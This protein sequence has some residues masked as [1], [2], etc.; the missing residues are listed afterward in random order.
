[1]PSK[2]NS[3]KGRRRRSLPGS[4]ALADVLYRSAKQDPTRRF[5]ALYDKVARRDILAEAWRQ[6][7]ANR[8]APG[9][10]GVTIEDV[11]SQ[12]PAAFLQQIQTE[13]TNRTYRP[14]RLRAVQ[15]EKP[16]KPGKY[17]TLGIPT[18]RDRTIMTAAA[19]VLQPIFEPQF[20]PAS[21][22]FRPGK[23]PQDALEA[24]RTQANRGADWVL[25]ADVQDAFGNLDHAA[26]MEEVS[27]RVCDRQM[28]KLIRAWLRAGVL[29]DQGV[30]DLPSG[31]PQGSPISPLL[32]NVALHRFDEQWQLSSSRIGTLVRFAD[33]WLILCRTRQGAEEAQRRATAILGTL[34]LQLNPDKTKVL[35]LTKGSQGLEFLGFHLH[36]VESWKYPGRY[37]LQRWPSQRSMASIRGRIRELTNRK[38]VGRA[39]DMVIAD[40]NP[41]LRGWGNYFRWGNSAAKLNAID[42]YVHERLAIFMSRKHKRQ[43]RNWV[44]R[45]NYTWFSTLGVYRL[46]GNTR[47][48]SAHAMR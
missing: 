42:S 4:R 12:G 6:V 43:G 48:G 33:D 47:Y 29:K 1:M 5:H 41:I 28:L 3:T 31:T 37:Y 10:D 46:T 11:E 26:L 15:I 34:G 38:Q 13:L 25:T 19:M 14:A 40:L 27:K 20:L 17:R 32:F 8:G 18:V 24:V 30:T 7:C 23:S 9:V 39:L 36:K 45:Y 22:G 35:C 44:S 21:F 2:A 16:G